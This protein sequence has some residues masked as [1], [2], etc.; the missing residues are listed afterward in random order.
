[1]LDAVAA[2]AAA[3]EATASTAAAAAAATLGE[4]VRSIVRRVYW[5]IL[6]PMAAFMTKMTD[7]GMKTITSVSTL[8]TTCMQNTRTP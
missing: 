6:T 2:A 8:R 4:Q 1:M 7:I 3:A 5:Q